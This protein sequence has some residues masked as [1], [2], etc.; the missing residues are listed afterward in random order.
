MSIVLLFILA[1]AAMLIVPIIILNIQAK[2]MDMCDDRRK[3][4][5]KFK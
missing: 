5:Q 4:N 2:H 1:V 3:K